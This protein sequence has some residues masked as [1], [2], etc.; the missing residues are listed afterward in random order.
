[1]PVGGIKEKV[2]AA[3]RAGIKEVLLPKE[4]RKD[5]EE[6]PRDVQEEMCFRFVENVDEVLTWAFGKNVEGVSLERRDVHGLG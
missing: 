2:L 6:I 5:L 4:N 3:H 1:M